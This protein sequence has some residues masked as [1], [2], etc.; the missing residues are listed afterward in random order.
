MKYSSMSFRTSFRGY[1]FKLGREILLNTSRIIFFLQ[2]CRHLTERGRNTFVYVSPSL[3]VYGP[4]I[5]IMISPSPTLN[6]FFPY[7]PWW[8]IWG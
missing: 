1:S 3:I 2:S 5:S 7:C 4:A 8:T 6:F